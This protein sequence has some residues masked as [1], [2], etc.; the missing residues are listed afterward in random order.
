[1]AAIGTI[2]K[3]SGIAVGLIGFAIIAFVVSDALTSN[4]NL[5]NKNKMDVGYV[6]GKAISYENFNSRLQEEYDKYSLQTGSETITEEQ[7]TKIRNDL[8]QIMTDE[9]VYGS[10]YQDIGLDVSGDELSYFISGPNPHPAV[11][12][13]FTNPDTKQFD[14]DRLVYFLKNMDQFPDVM[15]VWLDFE[16]NLKKEKLREK[17]F[18]L[19]KQSM[20]V[21]TVEAESDYYSKNQFANIDYIYLPISTLADST[22][23]KQ[24]TEKEIKARYEKIKKDHEVD[25]SR[26]FEYVVFDILP[27]KEDTA[28]MKMQLSHLKEEFRNTKSIENF[29]NLKSTEPF[30]TNYH[31]R[32]Y[33]NETIDKYFFDGENTDTIIGPYYENNLLKIARLI[34]KKED[35]AFYYK[36]RH[37]LIRPVNNDTNAA[38]ATAKEYMKQIKAG[39]DFGEL[40]KRHSEDPGSALKGGD[41]GWFREDGKTAQGVMVK[42]FMD[43]VVKTPKGKMTIAKTQF[44]VHLIQVTEA[45]E[46]KII[47]VAIISQQILPSSETFNMVYQKANNL[48][49]NINTIEDFE[50]YTKENGIVRRPADNIPPSALEVSGFPDSRSLINWAYNAKLGEISGIITIEN[51]YVVAAL[52]KITEEGYA[53]LEDL[54]DEIIKDLIKEK[55]QEIQY[56]AIVDAQGGQL[57]EIAEKL[58]LN[59]ENY[60]NASM[61]VPFFADKGEEKYA[62][63]TIFGMQ[64][65]Q[66]SNPIKGN[67]GAIQLYVKSFST[68]EAPK[69]LEP[70]K[71]ELLRNYQ[72]MSQFEAMNSLQENAKIEDLRYKFF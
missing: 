66:L 40:A 20:Y 12:Q 34:D 52:T 49:G 19:V 67:E 7:K 35:T 50:N 17:Y 60:P 28:N 26:S 25:E 5:F 48:R 11:Q 63:G 14:R 55:K 8:W 43:A 70:K 44:G 69:D 33:F 21:T 27:T 13:F 16:K 57:P 15:P 56:Q 41:L 6:K 68:V 47:H 72:G 24:I 1:M 53:T 59:V 30:D 54:R 2:R 18:N 37:I 29:V 3:Y 42:P 23:E 4:S 71:A 51:K 36:A 38:L 31:N 22:I 39:E 62:L 46:N 58:N 45:K 9:L 61:D 32:G 64:A 10:E 65:D